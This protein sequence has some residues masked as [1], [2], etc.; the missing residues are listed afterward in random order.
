MTNHR[1]IMQIGNALFVTTAPLDKGGPGSGNFGH[2]GRS[3]LRGGSGGGMVG[4]GGGSWTPPER[5]SD[6]NFSPTR[7]DGRPITNTPDETS[8]RRGL[9]VGQAVSGE[10]HDMNRDYHRVSGVII[11]FVHNNANSVGNSTGDAVIFDVKD[12]SVYYIA[13]RNVFGRQR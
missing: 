4:G 11:G 2:S 5:F 8:A 13:S 1:D 3:G 12:E 7:P 10:Y 6:Y 9:V